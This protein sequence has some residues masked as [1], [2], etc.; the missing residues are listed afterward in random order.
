MM[1]FE[2]T[3]LWKNAFSADA[4]PAEERSRE[5]LRVMYRLFWERTVELSRTIQ[6]DL[7]DL[8]LHDE[9]H[10]TAL[11]E[12]AAILAGTKLQINPLEAFV[13]GGAILLHDAGHALATY[14][15]GL[16]ELRQTPQWRDKLTMYLRS[17]DGEPA[18]KEA[19][20]NPPD[21]ISRQV[22]FDT[23]RALHAQKAVQLAMFGVISPKTGDTLHLIEDGELRHHLGEVIGQIAASHHWSLRELESRL[24]SRIGAVAGLPDSWTLDSIKIACLLRCSDAVQIDQRRT[25][26]FLYALLNISGTSDFHWR[27]QSHL[28]VPI[29]DDKDPEALLFT[30]STAFDPQ[31]ADAWWVAYDAINLADSELRQSDVFLRDLGRPTLQVKRVRDANSPKH[32]ASHIRT[33]GWR[34][35]AA[36]LKITNIAKVVALFGG[37]ALY[38]NDLIVPIREL[39]QNAADAVRARRAIEPSIS[40]YKGQIVISIEKGEDKEAEGFWLSVVDNGIG[41]SE[42]TLVGPLL[43]F[44]TSFWTSELL[45]REFPGLASANLRQTGRYGIGFFSVFMLTDRVIVDSRRYDKGLDE[46]RS[47]NFRGGLSLRPLLLE[48]P[49]RPVATSTSTRVSLFL[50]KETL[51][52][53]LAPQNDRKPTKV[54]LPELIGRLC[55]MLD[56]DVITVEEDG[57]RSI[58]HCADWGQMNASEWLYQIQLPHRRG[59]VEKEIRRT[60]D[61]LSCFIQPIYLGSRMIGRAGINFGRDRGIGGNFTDGGLLIPNGDSFWYNFNEGFYGCIDQI[62]SGPRRSEKGVTPDLSV[63]ATVQAKLLAEGNLDNTE[64]QTAAVCVA[65]HGGDPTPLAAVII[66][67]EWL[68]LPTAIQNFLAKGIELTFIKENHYEKGPTNYLHADFSVFFFTESRHRVEAHELTFIPGVA[69]LPSP[70]RI[71]GS[72]NL[73]G[74]YYLA[75]DPKSVNSNSFLGCFKRFALEQGFKVELEFDEDA[76]V[77]HRIPEKGRRERL[78]N[79]EVRSNAVRTRT[80][81]MSS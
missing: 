77:G 6:N 16:N 70:G 41:M 65:Y 10:F 64:R 37:K 15:G 5:R 55:P 68:T 78:V 45:Q 7:P 2:N 19:L 54:T 29:L 57:T 9:R 26:D 8:T 59:W 17:P 21:G 56:C 74:D 63:W 71:T 13:F 76:L 58:A 39:V 11:W 25:P 46:Q 49:V 42:D 53:V 27:F 35:I 24:Q 52:R 28:A 66:D 30:S 1:P 4:S 20:A 44:G 3:H 62:P 22:L 61:D 18:T 81:H 32:L 80:T 43:D 73:E 69:W 47:L 12:R 38:G 31:E 14:R 33:R 51:D 75:N 40:D 34:P 60:L 72:F 67:G 36:E 23:L 48:A 79:R 50:N